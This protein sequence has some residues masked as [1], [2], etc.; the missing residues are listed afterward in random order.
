M[1]NTV[2]RLD[3]IDTENFV[4]NAHGSHQYRSYAGLLN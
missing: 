2:N 4:F 3:L 1:N